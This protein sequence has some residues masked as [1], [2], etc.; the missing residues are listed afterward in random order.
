MRALLVSELQRGSRRPEGG[1]A[2]S[3]G[4]E[5]LLWARLGLSFWVETFKET[6]RSRSSLQDATRDGFKRS[7]AR[8]LDGFGRAAFN[9]AARQTPN[10]DVVR[11]RTHLGCSNGVCSE[12]QLASELRSFVKEV[13]PVLVRMTQLQKAVGL[14]DP[15]TP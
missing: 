13:E 12:E 9:V 2:R 15:R 1:P 7:L 8:Y 5:A 6:L 10:W 4:A 3:S 11:E 14:E